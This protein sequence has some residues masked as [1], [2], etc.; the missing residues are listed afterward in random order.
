MKNRFSEW[1]YSLLRIVSGLLFLG[2]GLQ[3]IFGVLG[4]NAMP[5]TSRYGAAGLIEI[6]CG[7]LIAAGA[8]TP[9]VAFV[10]SGEMAVAYFLSHAP[11]GWNPLANQGEQAVLYCFIFLFFALRGGGRL[12]ISGA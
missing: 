11:R 8:Y 7:A 3:K 9:I 10:A 6:V 5:L 1:T 2:H 4:G 12:R